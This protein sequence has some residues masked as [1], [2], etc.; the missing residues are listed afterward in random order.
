MV[1]AL[2]FV[3]INVMFGE[4]IIFISEQ[5]LIRATRSCIYGVPPVANLTKK[6]PSKTI[7]RMR[8]LREHAIT[9]EWRE[10]G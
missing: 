4:K 8:L 5:S 3:K 6:T 1:W 10:L 7:R 9:P 2:D